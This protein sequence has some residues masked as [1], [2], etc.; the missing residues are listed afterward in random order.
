MKI[1]EFNEDSQFGLM[2]LETV[3]E[4]F[5]LEDYQEDDEI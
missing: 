5:Y 1:K 2:R 4:L 3:R